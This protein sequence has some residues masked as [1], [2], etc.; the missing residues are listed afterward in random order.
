MIDTTDGGK[1]VFIINVKNL[2]NPHQYTIV[3]K[4]T[5]W[6]SRNRSGN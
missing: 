5:T 3:Y 4:D 1:A 2:S 6:Y